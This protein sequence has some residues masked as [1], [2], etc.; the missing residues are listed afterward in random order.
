LTSGWFTLPVFGIDKIPNLVDFLGTSILLV[1]LNLSVFSINSALNFHDNVLSSHLL[2]S[3]VKEWIS[4][5][6]ELEPS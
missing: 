4:P 2:L 1:H 6:E 3:V 5:H